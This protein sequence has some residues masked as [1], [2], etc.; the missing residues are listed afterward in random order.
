MILKKTQS[1]FPN[2]IYNDDKHTQN[3]IPKI[4]KTKSNLQ[5]HITENNKK[6]GKRCN[7]T[8]TTEK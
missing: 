3:Q 7:Q 1:T 5:R 4:S 2:P 8:N 6:L